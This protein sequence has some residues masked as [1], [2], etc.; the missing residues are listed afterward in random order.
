NQ[1]KVLFARALGG[2]PRVLLLDEPTRGVDISARY[3]LYRLI[4]QMTAEGLAVVMAS[5]DLPE[6][7]GL[8]DRIGVMRGGALAE[9]VPAEG[10]TEAGLLARFYHDTSK[11]RVA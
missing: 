10:L 8:S 2:G 4:R 5:S 7:I 1:Q 9:I 3:E 11:E 6:L